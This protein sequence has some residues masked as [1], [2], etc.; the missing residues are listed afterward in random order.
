MDVYNIDGHKL[1]YHLDRV[2]NWS[3][4]KRIAPL[5]I[6]MGIN[7]SCNVACTYCYYAVPENQKQDIIPTDRLINFFQ[8]AAEVGV[9]AIA[10][11]GDGEPTSHPGLYDALVAGKK[12]GL[13]LSLSTNGLVM[14]E[15]RIKDLLDSLVWLRIHISAASREGYVKVMGSGREVHDKFD[16]VIENIK[17][18]VEIKK[19]YNCPSTIGLQMILVPECIPEVVGL[20][21]LGKELGVNY[22]AIKP[23]AENGDFFKHEVFKYYDFE[24]VLKEAESYSDGDYNVIIKW[25]KMASNGARGYDNCYG[26]AFLPQINGRGDFYNCGHF[27]GK[28]EFMYG[29]IV[30]IGGRRIN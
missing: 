18:T 17:K 4:G 30:E 15:S 3:Q 10:I 27:Y 8:E 9:R 26:C 7:Q 13:D 5:Y 23:F 28:E 19:K 29:N 21:K 14:Q 16:K 22:V 20:A 12:C 24:S 2:S 6:D 25:D 11:A 1:I